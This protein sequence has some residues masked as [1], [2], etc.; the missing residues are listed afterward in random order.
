M[1]K[2]IIFDCFGVITENRWD[3]FRAAVNTDVRDQ[4]NDMHTAFDRGLVSY[5]DFSRTLHELTGMSQ[6]EIDAVFMNRDGY[7]K[8]IELL[9]DIKELSAKYKVSILSNVGSNWIREKFLT[10]EEINLFSDFVLS[11][12]TKLGKPDPAIYQLAFE[13]LGVDSSEAVFIDDNPSYCQV[14]KSMGAKTIAY[15]NFA[16]YKQEL[17]TILANSNN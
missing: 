15:T 3:T 6:D 7:S 10:T 4:V 11:Y 12:E 14:A 2:A 13:R 16:Q 17:D 8:N 9:A 5:P 1:I